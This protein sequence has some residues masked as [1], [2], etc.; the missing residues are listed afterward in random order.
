MRPH[1]RYLRYVLLHKWYVLLGGLQIHGW[2]PSWIWRLLVHD[3]SKFRPSEW[4]PYVANFYGTPATQKSESQARLRA[5]DAAWLKHQHR[6]Q[7][8]WQHWILREDSGV[9]KVLVPPVALVDE[10]VADWLGAGTKILKYP[11]L[12]TLVA[13][14]IVWYLNNRERIQLRDVTRQRVEAILATLAVNF[15]QPAM[16]EAIAKAAGQTI[17]ITTPLHGGIARIEQA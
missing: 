1:L 9:T 4:R 3:L 2:K 14:T 13:E 6:N 8:H 11:N 17:R 7:H 5:F 16:V 15:E 10:M 12:D